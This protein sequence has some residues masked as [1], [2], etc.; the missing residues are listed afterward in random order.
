MNTADSNAVLLGKRNS[1]V[2]FTS[3]ISVQERVN[4]QNVLLFAES[5][6][7]GSSSPETHWHRWMHIYREMLGNRGV[8]LEQTILG[9]S[10]LLSS[11]EDL[12][13]AKFRIK[14]VAETASLADLVHRS[15]DAMGV[16][17]IVKA[18]FDRGFEIGGFKYFQI[19]PCEKTVSGMLSVLLCGLALSVDTRSA[20]QRRLVFHFKGGSY[21]FDLDLYAKHRESVTA[22]LRNK[23]I[24]S[25]RH[26]R[27]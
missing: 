26:I 13:E 10:V 15:F 2:A 18:Y 8:K 24:A 12:S 27:I 23:A 22:Y 19:V 17:G 21:R 1:L 20:G 9:D 3:E 7:S 5:F 11:A 4:I 25:I 14:G 16:E 6:A